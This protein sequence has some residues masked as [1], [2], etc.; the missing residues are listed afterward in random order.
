MYIISVY[1]HV[2]AACSFVGSMIFFAGVIVPWL[3]NPSTQTSVPLFLQI[4]GIRYRYF[5][6]IALGLLIITGF[7]SILLRGITL[8]ILLSGEFWG[9]SFG[10]T[11]FH[12]LVFVGLVIILTLL[13]D[14][15]SSGSRKLASWIGRA[16]FL[17]TLAV[18]YYAISL[19]RI[20]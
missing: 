2:L 4:A 19:T 10:K 17:F 1:L 11:L 18:L 12:K 15:L 13:H 3:R 14:I 6:W 7:S 20:L 5:A 16:I 9:S 8:E